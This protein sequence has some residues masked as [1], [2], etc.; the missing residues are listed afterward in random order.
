MTAQWVTGATRVRGGRAAA[1]CSRTASPSARRRARGLQVVRHPGAGEGAR[2]ARRLSRSTSTRAAARRARARTT[3]VRDLIEQVLFTAPGERVNRPTFGSGLLAARLRAEQRRARRRD[4]ADGAG[5][6]PAVARRPDRGRGRRRSRG[7][8]S[9]LEVDGHVRQARRRR[10]GSVDRRSRA[11]V[12]AVSERPRLPLLRRPPPRGASR[13]RPLQRHRL[14]R[15][16]R[17]GRHRPGRPPARAARPLRESRPA[18]SPTRRPGS[19]RDDVDHR[20]RR[21][22]PRHP[23]RRGGLR[24]RRR[25]R[26]HASIDAGRLL[27]LHPAPRRRGHRRPPPRASTRCSRRSTSR[28]RSTARAT[29]T[30]RPDVRLPARAARRAGDRL[31]RQGLRE[32]PAADARPAGRCSRPTGR[33]ATRPTSAS[34]SSSCSPTSATT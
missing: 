33:S 29:S 28:S 24:R 4:A 8:D 7:V 21:A 1:R 12:A 17:L 31:P 34:R 3:H 13:E 6:A 18:T 20:G 26:R 15:G 16:R 10:S 2:D 14:P 25:A 19:G 9:T 11:E 22:D 5:R 32:L 23:G 30:A 27:D